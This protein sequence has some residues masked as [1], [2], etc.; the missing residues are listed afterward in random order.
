MFLIL[1]TS[2]VIEEFLNPDY[3]KL[4]LLTNLHS[5]N[6][7]AWVL[8]TDLSLSMCGTIYLLIFRRLQILRAAAISSKL[9]TQARVRT[10]SN[11]NKVCLVFRFFILQPRP[12][13]HFRFLVFLHVVNQESI[14]SN[15]YISLLQIHRYVIFVTSLQFLNFLTGLSLVS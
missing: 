7:G 12:F 2:N 3:V 6:Y 1:C 14:F 13:I 4:A 9:H 10:L 15:V 5:I 8:R 11:P